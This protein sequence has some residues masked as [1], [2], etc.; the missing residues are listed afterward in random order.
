MLHVILQE[1]SDF[2]RHPRVVAPCRLDRHLQLIL[3]EVDLSLTLIY[4][5]IFQQ[6]LVKVA[7]A[8]LEVP[9]QVVSLFITHIRYAFF[10]IITCE[11][12]EI[13]LGLRI[14]IL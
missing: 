14:I 2:I 12:D 8:F 13:S 10:L 1:L 6:H 4:S 9:E 5:D 11:V 7:L 3:V